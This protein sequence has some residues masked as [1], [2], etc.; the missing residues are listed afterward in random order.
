MEAAVGVEEEEEGRVAVRAVVA[1][2]GAV[3]VN[4]SDDDAAATAADDEK[5][6]CAMSAEVNAARLDSAR[7]AVDSCCV[8]RD[9]LLSEAVAVPAAA[10]AAEEALRFLLPA[11][12]GSMRRG[13]SCSSVLLGVAESSIIVGDRRR[14]PMLGAGDPVMAISSGEV[15]V[16]A[17]PDAGNKV[18]GTWCVVLLWCAKGRSG[19]VPSGFSAC[20]RVKCAL[21]LLMLA[22]LSMLWPD[23]RAPALPRLAASIMPLGAG[24]SID[25]EANDASPRPEEGARSP[26]REVAGVSVLTVESG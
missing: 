10:A 21:K 7:P 11:A 5:G 9:S 25:G 17:A 24:D 3:A 14:P 4:P 2:D 26:Y 16:E 6:N 15:D 13:D 23:R 20:L 22:G 19:W 8:K 12:C 18:T 1:V